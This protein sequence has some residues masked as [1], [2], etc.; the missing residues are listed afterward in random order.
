MEQTITIDTEEGS[1]DAFLAVPSGD[2]VVPGMVVAQE[3]FG[4]NDHIRTVCRRLAAAGYAALAPELYH[5]SGAGITLPYDDVPRVMPYMAMVTN[6]GLVMDVRAALVELRAQ[7]R[8][9]GT[10]VGV[11]GFCLGGLATF[12]AACHTDA[13]TFVSFYGGGIVHE[14]PGLAM[15]P[16]LTEANRITRSILLFFGGRDTSIPPADVA[17][18]RARLEA[19]HTKHRIVVYPDAQHGFACEERPSYDAMS[20]EAAWN[21]TWEWLQRELAGHAAEAV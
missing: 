4:V 3:A 17:S 1:M 21:V 14:R 11:I 8:V 12:I 7:P 6:G 16:P 10:R 9:D 2:E 19:L 20:A 13:R 5:R 18:I 15:R